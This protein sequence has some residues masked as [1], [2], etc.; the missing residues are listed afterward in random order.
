MGASAIPPQPG[1][2]TSPSSAGGS[3]KGV[4]IGVAVA[5]VLLIGVVA[6]LAL[7]GSDDKSADSNVNTGAATPSTQASTT[8]TEASTSTEPTDTTDTTTSTTPS[9]SETT[10]TT[11]APTTPAPTT[12]GPTPPPT[13]PTTPGPTIPPPAR[14]VGDPASG[15]VKNTFRATAFTVTL[16]NTGG[17]RGAW[18]L[19]G[20]ALSV[21][22]SS[23]TLEPGQTINV[24]VT[25]NPTFEGSTNLVGALAGSG[26]YNLGVFVKTQ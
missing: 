17:G 12:P 25:P 7:G 19:S 3:K 13:V 20:R 8:T 2:S 14:I 26:G 9:T 16:T 5:V 1:A 6:A 21:S 15:T 24:M 18:Q 4:L 10:A 22:P 11:T 23:G